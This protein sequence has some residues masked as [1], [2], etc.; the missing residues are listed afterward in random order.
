VIWVDLL[1]NGICLGG[2]YG[3]LGVGIALATGV[4]RVI[5]IAHGEFIVLAGM[6]GI[7]LSDFVVPVAIVFFFVGYAVQAALINKVITAP[8]LL[9]PI[10]L[11][12]GLSTVL[13][14]LMMESFGADVRSL[15]VGGFGQSSIN[16]LGV[17]IGVLPLV[18]LALTVLFFVGLQLLISRTELGRVVRATADNSDVARLMGV[19]PERVYKIV[20][21]MSLALAGVGGI[22]L[23]MRATITPFSGVEN[24]LIA[25]E[26]VVLGGFGSFWG[27]LLG[28]IA[29]GIAQIAGLRLDPNAGSLY[30][31]VLFFICVL[32]RPYGLF[33]A[34]MQ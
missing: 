7:G 12:F 31:H 2:L 20:M 4:M 1:I 16:V 3:M 18:T 23:A 10:L 14:N 8:D 9:A 25:F 27:A 30:G 21:G 19:T 28:G 33:G 29:L 15:H 32:V 24:L 5:N 6:L 11:T 34:R 26:V 13:R 22:L 17:S